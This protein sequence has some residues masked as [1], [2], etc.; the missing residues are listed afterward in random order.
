MRPLLVLHEDGADHAV[1][2]SREAIAQEFGLTPE[3]RMERLPSGRVTTLQN[4]V[5]W[6]TT[7]LFRTGLLDRPQRAHYRI[8]DRG[9]EVLAENPERVD[10]GVLRQFDELHEFIGGH[11]ASSGTAEVP[12][13]ATEPTG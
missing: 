6:A 1:A 5:G 7:Y 2:D 13:A 4:R 8:T 9:R 3:D 11:A 12:E 10:L